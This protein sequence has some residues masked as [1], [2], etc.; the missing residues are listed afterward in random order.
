MKSFN[1]KIILTS[2]FSMFLFINGCNN[3]SGNNDK[4]NFGKIGVF[5]VNGKRVYSPY[6]DNRKKP[7][8]TERKTTVNGQAEITYLIP[9]K[10]KGPNIVL[11]PGFGLSSSIY[12]TTPDERDGWVQMFYQKGYSIY[13]MTPPDR[14]GSIRV[15]II[16]AC[17]KDSKKYD[18]DSFYAQL[19]YT[20]LENP[21]QTWGFGPKFGETFSD[22]KFPAIPLK[23]NYIEQ[24][25]ASFVVYQGPS[26]LTMTEAET[27]NKTSEEAIK[28]LLEKVGPSVLVLHS[29]SGTAGYKVAKE[30]P[31]LIKAIVAI[32]T[33]ECPSNNKSGNSPLG[34][35][36]FLGIW[37]DHIYER[38]EEGN[39]PARLK[40][41]KEMVKAIKKEGKVPAELIY[42]PE[43]LEIYGN[44]HIMMQDSN[45]E[46][47][48]NIISS[49]L[50]NNIK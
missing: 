15:D 13:A 16:N 36:P 42:L 50:K 23:E 6:S 11:V 28:G 39:H 26:N 47:I 5:F 32:E 18:C 31:S 17:L 24:F 33:T 10:I 8:P 1:K 46:E 30:N 27:M 2:F 22:S 41:C 25:G 48:A 21:W 44:S 14:A 19:G 12:L 34:N 35:I 37:G 9:P 20:S 3:S 43:D 29:A 7:F 4:N 45:N 38:G 40:S 49:W